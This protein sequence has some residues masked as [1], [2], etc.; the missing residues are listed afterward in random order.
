M[1]EL[2]ELGEPGQQVEHPVDG[3][4]R[5][6]GVAPGR[7]MSRTKTARSPW[8]KVGTPHTSWSSAAAVCSARTR[9]SACAAVD[10]GEHR[11]GVDAVRR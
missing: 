10:L 5:Q 4:G 7:S 9:S 2:V 11:V 6:L 1:L 3:A 8:M